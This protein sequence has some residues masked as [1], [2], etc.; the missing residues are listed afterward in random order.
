[1]SGTLIFSLGNWEFFKIKIKIIQTGL[2]SDKFRQTGS[3]KIENELNQLFTWMEEEKKY[4]VKLNLNLI[5]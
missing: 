1:M 4:R 2:F 3:Q 5:L